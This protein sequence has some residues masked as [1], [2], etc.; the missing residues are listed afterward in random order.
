MTRVLVVAHPGLN[1]MPGVAARHRNTAMSSVLTGCHP[2]VRRV[3][4]LSRC[5]RGQDVVFMANLGMTRLDGGRRAVLAVTGVPGGMKVVLQALR[6]HCPRVVSQMRD[7][8]RAVQVN[9][10][11]TRNAG[12]VLLQ[13]GKFAGI[14][15]VL[16]RHLQDPLACAVWVV[17]L[18]SVVRHRFPLSPP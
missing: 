8:A 5:C 16:E 7:P 17:P 11:H 9:A 2:D 12:Q 3:P 6:H 4:C 15:A 13:V 14:E 18:V 1:L 10:R